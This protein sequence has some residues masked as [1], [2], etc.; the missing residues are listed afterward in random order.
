[1]MDDPH[2]PEPTTTYP[3]ETGQKRALEMWRRLDKLRLDPQRPA[4][5]RLEAM[6]LQDVI[7]ARLNRPPKGSNS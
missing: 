4:E 5:D 7:E 2:Q 1:M 6:R 3:S